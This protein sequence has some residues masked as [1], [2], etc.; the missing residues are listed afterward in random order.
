MPRKTLQLPLQFLFPVN[1]RP[2]YAGKNIVG[3][4]RID[5]GQQRLWTTSRNHPKQV[6]NFGELG[7]KASGASIN[8]FSCKGVDDDLQMDRQAREDDRPFSIRHR[9]QSFREENPVSFAIGR[10]ANSKR[11][12]N[13]IE[14]SFTCSISPMISG[15][16]VSR[17]ASRYSCPASHVDWP[18]CPRPPRL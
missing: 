13:A 2:R 4:D 10:E 6:W 7:L 12:G 16:T 8:F 9:R 14:A 3:R 15:M 11:C 1:E 5:F 17:W 18:G